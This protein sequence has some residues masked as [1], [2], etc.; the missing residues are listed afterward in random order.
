MRDPL[1]R[2]SDYYPGRDVVITTLY[3]DR[4][5]PTG[6]VTITAVEQRWNNLGGRWC[7]ITVRDATG[8][9]HELDTRHAFIVSTEYR[10]DVWCPECRT[11]STV[12]D[13]F[14]HGWYERDGEHQA[15]VTVL[16]CGHRVQ[17][18][19][20]VVGGAPGAPYAG[21]GVVVAASQSPRDRLAA[22]LAQS[23]QSA[24]TDP[25]AEL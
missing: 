12:T 13:E 16:A 24:A 23:R 11:S 25:W 4:T 20:R 10:R 3:G 19:D 7:D 17:S 1:T 21:P 9:L 22:A 2:H 5:E 6:P 18:G 8:R 14:S 15:T